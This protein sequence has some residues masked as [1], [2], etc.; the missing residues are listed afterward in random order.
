MC[1]LKTHEDRSRIT[2]EVTERLLGQGG[3]RYAGRS[4]DAEDLGGICPPRLAGFAARLRDNGF[5]VGLAET[6][7]ALAILARPPPRGRRRCEPALRALFCA[8]RSDWERFDEI[9]EAYWRGRGM[10]RAQA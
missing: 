10:R 7:D 3:V 4:D 9:F 5:M 1:L 8:T 6:R 2:R